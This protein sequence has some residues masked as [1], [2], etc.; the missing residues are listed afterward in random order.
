[1]DIA[2]LS[3]IKS[4]A[5]LQQDV[6]VAMMKKVMNTAEQRSNFINEMLGSSS[7]SPQA[8]LP[9]MGNNIDKYV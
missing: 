4:Q 9:H 5:Q 6:G 7:K 2:A 3:M 1:M 8:N